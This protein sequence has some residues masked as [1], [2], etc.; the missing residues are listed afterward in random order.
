MNCASSGPLG[1][2]LASLFRRLGD[3]LDRID[4]SLAD[5][6]R[7][8]TILGSLGAILAVLEPSWTSLGPSWGIAGRPGRLLS[9]FGG[10]L[11]GGV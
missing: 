3:L 9:R 8:W 1:K 2:P 6:K 4:P 5:L 7:V 11:G 10:L